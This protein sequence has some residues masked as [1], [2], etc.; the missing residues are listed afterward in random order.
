MSQDYFRRGVRVPPTKTAAEAAQVAFDVLSDSARQIGAKFTDP[1]DD[2]TPAWVVL[3]P[4]QGTIITAPGSVAN[5]P[6]A[7]TAATRYVGDYARRNGA[8]A[9]GGLASVWMVELSAR[10]TRSASTRKRSRR[11]LMRGTGRRRACRVSS[12]CW[13]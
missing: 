10:P 11:W 9:I 12:G 1:E 4:E 6:R 5:D 3:T 2:W 7:K 13:S 8:V